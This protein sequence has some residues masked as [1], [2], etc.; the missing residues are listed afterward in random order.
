MPTNDGWRT[1][2]PL[3]QH[4]PEQ[5][6]LERRLSGDD[7]PGHRL[8]EASLAGDE[9]P[10]GTHLDRHALTAGDADAALAHRDVAGLGDADAALLDVDRGGVRLPEPALL[11][12]D[13]LDR[14]GRDHRRGRLDD[15]LGLRRGSG[16]DDGGA[17]P[18]R[19]PDR[20]GTG[21]GDLGRRCVG[22]D[23]GH[24]DQAYTVVIVRRRGILT[25]RRPA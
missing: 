9:Q 15:R 10:S 23:V 16:H 8:G 18:G 5:A 13:P 25:R 11:D 19:G 6:L 14:G 20:H 2:D 17:W 1:V 12:A 21:S 3:G 4:R 24:D 22:W 7:R